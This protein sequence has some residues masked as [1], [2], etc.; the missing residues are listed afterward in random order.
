MPRFEYMPRLDGLRALAVGGVFLDH[1]AHARMIH[2]WGPGHAGVVLFF[3]LSGFLITSILLE[4]RERGSGLG[5]AAARFY[6][7]RLLRLS[8]ALWLAIAAAA[9]LGVANMRHD[10][11]KHGLYLTNIMIA[12]HGWGGPAHFWTLSVE[13]QFYLGWFFVV[14]VAPRRWLVPAMLA[15]LVIGP[16]YRAMLAQPDPD[17]PIVLLPGQVD[18]LALGALLAYLRQRPEGQALFRRLQSPALLAA[19]LAMAVLLCIPLGWPYPLLKG[20]QPLA[21]AFASA[22]AI[23]LAAKPFAPGRGG[24]LDWPLARHVGRISYGLYVY[25]WF[26]P[27][28]L[29]RFGLGQLIDPPGAVPKLK[30]AALLTLLTFAAA[31]ASWWCVEKPILRLKDRLDGWLGPR[32]RGPVAAEAQLPAAAADSTPG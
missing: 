20:L 26:A 9:A 12:R 22:C 4:E 30:S 16:A 2:M 10:W 32:T 8:P 18:S 11:W 7:R 24:P 3:V 29:G 13:E 5:E 28:A 27:Q 23:A 25:H 15:C 14:V 6:G 19:F 31:E 21:V 17:Q 1:F